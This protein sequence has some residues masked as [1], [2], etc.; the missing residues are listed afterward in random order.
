MRAARAAAREIS[1]CPACATPSSPARAASRRASMPRSTAASAR[2]TRRSASRENRA[3]MAAQ[4][5]VAAERLLVPF[6]IHS[7]RCADVSARP[8]R[9]R[10][11]A[12]RRARDARRRPRARRHRRRL[13]HAAFRRRAAP[14]SSAP[15]MPAGR[16]RSTGMIE[17]TVDAMEAHG[18]RRA[19]IHVALG[20]A[21][22]ADEL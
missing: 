19:D 21:I 10:A 18:A 22:G 2:R 5:G 13:R 16:A 20:P 6:Q 8:G 17:A 14:A 11:A 9:R 12:L 1:I 15:A 3:R 7:R 4:L